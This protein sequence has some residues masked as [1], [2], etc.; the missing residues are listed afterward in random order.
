MKDGETVADRP[1]GGWTALIDEVRTGRWINPETGEPAPPAQHDMIVI[2]EDLDGAEPALVA[3]LGM[4]GRLAVVADRDTWDALGSR[5]ARNLGGAAAVILDRPHA[6]LDTVADLTSRLAG[7][8]GIIAV[9]SGTVNDLCKY[10]TFQDGRRYCVFG[11]A[12]SMDGYTSTTA[13]MTLESGLKISLP[14]HGAAG[15]FLDLKVSAA[16]PGYLSAAGSATACVARWRRSTGGCHTASW[17]PS[18]PKRPT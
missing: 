18:T 3:E 5:I 17:T 6:D 7:Y 12:A 4:T 1:D 16:A 10:V 11:T 2:A 9:G 13:S 15:V 8:D 14:A